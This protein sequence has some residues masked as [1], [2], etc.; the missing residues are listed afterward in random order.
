MVMESTPLEITS[1]PK[2]LTATVLDGGLA[3]VQNTNYTIQNI[4]NSVIYIAEYADEPTG[5]E[6]DFGY[7][8]LKNETWYVK[9]T[10]N[11][12][13]VWTVGYQISYIIV[14]ESP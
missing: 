11:S 9:P 5:D 14:T 8:I 4:R 7:V 10:G 6:L 13:W 2:D 12:V 3:L 1:T